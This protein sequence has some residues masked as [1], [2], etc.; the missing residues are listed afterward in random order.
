MPVA[1]AVA[2]AIAWSGRRART[3][4]VLLSVAVA[5]KLWP[6][7]LIP[8]LVLR[9]RR[10]ERPGVFVA[11]VLPWIIIELVGVLTWGTRSLT[12]PWTWQQDRGLQI[13]SSA[14]GL[15][16]ILHVGSD[17]IVFRFNAWET[18]SP[19]WL[20]TLLTLTGAA[21]LVLVITVS[22][23]RLVNAQVSERQADDIVSAAACLVIA[24]LLVTGKVF[25][26]QYLLWLIAPLTVAYVMREARDRWMFGLMSA[27]CALTTLI[28]P[29]M[30]SK[31]IVGE[32][33]PWSV[34]QLRN[35]LLVLVV[36]LLVARW[37]ASM[38]LPSRLSS[39]SE[40]NRRVS[41]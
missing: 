24:V 21:I 7:V 41:V 35:V 8:L 13:E 14:A 29:V 30:Y 38:T 4:A 16:R 32:A 2:L 17:P 36:G 37:R 26:P 33:L 25:S 34:L 31:L 10:A 18:T 23:R 11:A 9:V 28:Y 22:C 12:A 15:L 6:I 1:C 27:I 20:L 39:E 3:A 40:A 19:T 5:L